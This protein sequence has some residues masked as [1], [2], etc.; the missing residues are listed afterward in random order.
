MAALL[1]AVD[2]AWLS[3]LAAEGGASAASELRS[4]ASALQQSL[5]SP[6]VASVLDARLSLLPSS[7]R[8]AFCVPSNKA[9]PQTDTSLQAS[10]DA[11]CVY[12]V[13]NS[14]GLQPRRTRELISEELDN[15]A[16]LGVN[17]HFCGKRPWL[18]IDENVISKS[19][20]VVGALPSEVA[21]MNSLTVNLHLL[22]VSFY[23]P[24]GK[25][26]RIMYEA[27]AFGS[28]FFAFESQARVH[29]L[30]PKE[31]LLPLKPREGE[32]T[33]RTED[34]VAAIEAAGDTLCTLCFGTI[35]YYTGQLFDVA[36]ITA[37]AQ[38]VGGKALWDC[39]HAAGN[40]DLKL[41]DWGVDGACWCSYKYLNSGPGGIGGFFVHERHHGKDLPLLAGWWGQ[42]QA[43]RFDMG[44][45]WQPEAD[46]SAWRLSN[47][48]VLQTVAL[49]A[50]L[51]VFARTSMSEL[52]GR[53]MLLTAYLELL[54]LELAGEG[55]LSVITPSDPKSR[56]C[57][58]SLK[59]PSERLCL[60]TFEGLERRGVVVDHRKPNVIRVA[61]APLY[62]NFSDV[63]RFA[64][65]LAES[66]QE[67]KGEPA[68]KK[69][70]S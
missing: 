55:G 23:R 36:P 7:Q 61:P 53:S 45:E 24:Q 52:R 47:P 14:L 25:R 8:N 46:A 32:E 40:I 58:L 16:N 26:N 41:H 29:G 17:G 3:Q 15:W 50:S 38:K 64:K 56:G 70:K 27:A 65:A 6:E 2:S 31:V 67:A 51:E 12:L 22:L 35:Q 37:A 60:E 19:A 10:P 68:A 54:V 63:Q 48:P 69:A 4:A 18:P 13:G 57:Q 33:L 44:H 62:N 1:G 30:D 11:D 9:L 28:D 5:N 43:S 66:M 59:F 21:V 49:M 34:V 42:K 39:A 20:A